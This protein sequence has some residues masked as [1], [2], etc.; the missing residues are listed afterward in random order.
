MR[1][2]FRFHNPLVS[3]RQ[4]A[5]N[6]SF[7]IKE[8]VLFESLESVVTIIIDVYV[9]CDRNLILITILFTQSNQTKVVI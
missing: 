9:L 8:A 3:L 6:H 7:Q 1:N 5:S 4:T 2:W